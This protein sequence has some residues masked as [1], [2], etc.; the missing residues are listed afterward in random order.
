M[1]YYKIAIKTGL[2]PDQAKHFATAMTHSDKPNLAHLTI[3]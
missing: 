3:K 1:D 2:T